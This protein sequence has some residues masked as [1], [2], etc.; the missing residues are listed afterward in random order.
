[1]LGVII[2]RSCRKLGVIYTRSSRNQSYFVFAARFEF[3]TL[4]RNHNPNP[5]DAGVRGGGERVLRRAQ[6]ARAVM[7]G[8]RKAPQ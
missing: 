5:R 8:L 7:L 4:L 1:M 3:F 6:P 2:T